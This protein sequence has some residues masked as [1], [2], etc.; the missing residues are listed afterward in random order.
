MYDTR[1]N[2][3]GKT[4]ELDDTHQEMGEG[5]IRK[6]EAPVLAFGQAPCG[7][8]DRMGGGARFC[9]ETIGKRAMRRRRM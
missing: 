5:E 7:V 3:E 1:S 4:T 2:S 9:V 8:T 6:A